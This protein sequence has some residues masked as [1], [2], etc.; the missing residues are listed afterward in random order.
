MAAQR[1]F[2][3]DF[4]GKVIE[5]SP[6]GH[7]PSSLE[8]WFTLTYWEGIGAVNHYSFCSLDCLRAWLDKHH[9]QVPDVYL[10][11]FDK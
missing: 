8:K 5:F 7:S 3:C 10:K 4:C 2:S 11:S 1:G 6:A 9:T